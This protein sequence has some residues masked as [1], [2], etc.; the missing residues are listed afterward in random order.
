MQNDVSDGITTLVKAGYVD[1]NRVSIVG[2]SYGGYSALAGGAFSPDL[3][4]C[5]ISVN[6]VSD[7]PKMLKSQKYKYGSKHWVT[8]YWH[9]I[10]GDS[11]SEIDKLRSVSPANF[12]PDFKAPVLLIHGKDDTVVP[13]EQSKRMHKAL[14]KAGKSVELITI[15]GEDHWLSASSTRLQMLKAIDDFLGIHNPTGNMAKEQGE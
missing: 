7:L 4:R 5:I 10:V 9:E 12:A 6:G 8:N 2:A 3:Y 11:K 14:K 1:P 15:D 13:I